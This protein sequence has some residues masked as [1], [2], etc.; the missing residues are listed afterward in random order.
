MSS[1]VLWRATVAAGAWTRESIESAIAVRRPRV[2]ILGKRLRSRLLLRNGLLRRILVA[3]AI[4]AIGDCLRD[5]ALAAV[6]LAA[7]NSV[8]AAGLVFVAVKL[9]SALFAL[10]GG[11]V[12]D[13]WDARRVMVTADIVR[14]LLVLLLPVA[15]LVS[16][17]AVYVLLFIASGLTMLFTTAQQSSIPG[18][19]D[20]D[21][22][23]G[24]N[25]LFHG[26]RYLTE[27]VGYSIAGGFVTLLINQL[28]AFDGTR[29]AFGMDALTFFASAT[30]LLGLPRRQQ[31]ITTTPSSLD[32]FRDQFSQTISFLHRQPYVRANF[33]LFAIVPLALGG[34]QTLWVGHAWRV[35]HTE[36]NR[37]CSPAAQL[38]RRYAARTRSPPAPIT[39]SERG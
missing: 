9:P 23:M 3:Y 17:P 27:I 32:K 16:L 11:F 34:F 36:S 18:W 15:V 22:L 14:G 12:I 19:V 28:G 2:M 30:L 6:I 39:P 31:L 5:V 1:Q 38:G 20:A 25:S 26:A 10:V 13:R 8:L 4:S 37:L 7:T 21:D 35:S 24:A 33:V 29:I